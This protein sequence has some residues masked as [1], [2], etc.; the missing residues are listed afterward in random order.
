MLGYT[1]E[2]IKPVKLKLASGKLPNLRGTFYQVGPAWKK[3]EHPFDGQGYVKKVVFRGP[4]KAPLY[5]GAFVKTPPKNCKAFGGPLFS[6]DGLHNPANTSIAFWGGKILCFFDGGAPYVLDEADLHTTGRYLNFK[7]GWP[8]FD[9]GDCIN[10]H[11]KIRNDRLVLMR[12]HYDLKM[13]TAVRFIEIDQTH[14]IRKKVDMTIPDFLYMHDFACVGEYYI[15]VHHPLDIDFKSQKGI[16]MSLIQQSNKPSIL[17]IVNRQ[18]GK[19]T[20]LPI[21]EPMFISH[22][23]KSRK[24][25]SKL[26]FEFISYSEYL[27]PP[28]HMTK[29]LVDMRDGSYLLSKNTSQWM[30]FPHG[31]YALCGDEHPMENL[32]KIDSEVIHHADVITEPVQHGNYV[33]AYSTTNDHTKLIVW[34]QNEIICELNLPDRQVPMGLH[35]TFVKSTKH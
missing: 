27:K 20:Q 21:K 17:Y 31:D 2:Y 25:D 7:D 23:S 12:L 3:D 34:Y 22:F 18:T 29:L 32:C 6:L 8:L 33:M 4:N 35:G 5:Q 30:E 13:N 15:V 10:S 9:W 14:K 19:V 16:A 1:K 28:G 24:Y 11:Y 26:F